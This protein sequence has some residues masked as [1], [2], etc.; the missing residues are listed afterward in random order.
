[1]NNEICHQRGTV[2]VER[3]NKSP[4]QK[5]DEEKSRRYSF[6]DKKINFVV[7]NEVSVNFKSRFFC[8]HKSTLIHYILLISTVKYFLLNPTN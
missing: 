3:E 4:R 5:I 7:T 6:E 2:S 8:V 1:M